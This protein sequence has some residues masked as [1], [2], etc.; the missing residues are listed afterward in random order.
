MPSAAAHHVA[1]RLVGD[2]RQT[3]AGKDGV[4]RGDQIGRG[5]DQR[6]VEIEDTAAIMVRDRYLPAA[7]MARRCRQPGT[8]M[9]EV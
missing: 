4:E 9:P 5:V 8:R 3:F 2:R 1:G 7:A 6:P